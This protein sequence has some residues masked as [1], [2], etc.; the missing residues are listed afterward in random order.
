MTL[1]SILFT[2]VNR[3]E[4]AIQ[5]LQSVYDTKGDNPVEYVAICDQDRPTFEAVRDWLY[6]HAWPDFQFV[7]NEKRT[8]AANAWNKAASMCVGDYLFPLGDDQT[9][10]PG[11][12]DQAIAMSELTGACIG[13]NDLMHAPVGDMPVVCTTLFYSR[14]FCVSNFGGVAAIPHYKYLCVDLELNERA[15]RVGKLIWLPN[16]I[17]EHRHSAN[18][19][20]PFDAL[21]E[22]KVFIGESDMQLF[23]SRKAAGFPDDFPA[24]VK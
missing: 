12:L 5:T 9:C 8:G 14:Q 24:C 21:D 7:F 13:L 11:W 4:S 6:G 3:K 22:E 2:T 15:K 23:E 19:K 10:Y 17:V 1:T 20:R 18:G 16:A